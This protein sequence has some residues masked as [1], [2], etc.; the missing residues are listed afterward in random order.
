MDHLD[1]WCSRPKVRI[2]P[3]ITPVIKHWAMSSTPESVMGLPD[4]DW[5]LNTLGGSLTFSPKT[6]PEKDSHRPIAALALLHYRRPANGR[7]GRPSASMRMADP[8]VRIAYPP[9]LF[10]RPICHGGASIS[11]GIFIWMAKFARYSRILRNLSG[12][13][14]VILQVAAAYEWPPRGVA[15]GP[16]RY[17]RCR[18]QWPN[19]ERGI[20]TR[21]YAYGWIGRS[22]G[23]TRF[24]NRFSARDDL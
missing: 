16:R 7:A 20:P 3:G 14:C 17:H 24:R 21:I 12:P 23:H 1:Q 2:P 5:M 22:F 4:D 19:S 13:H 11:G 10:Q 9:R 15:G 6:G 8:M 18:P